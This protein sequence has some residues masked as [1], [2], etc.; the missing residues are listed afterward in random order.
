MKKICIAKWKEFE[1]GKLF[2]IKK[3]KRL[4]KADMREGDINFIGASAVNNGVTAK[5]ANNDYLHQP[6][7]ITVNYNGSVGVSFYQTEP[8][9]A[10]DDVNIL[11]PKFKL[12]KHIAMFIIPIL[13]CKGKQYAFVDKWKKE[14]MEKDIILLPSTADGQPDWAYM[15]AYIK[16]IETN[17]CN[18]IDLLYNDSVLVSNIDGQ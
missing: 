1:I 15:E 12:N 10:S 6:N 3:G 2:E 17:V 13:Q 18:Y 5:I 11:Y 16:S 7:T 8:F 4:T 9:W 14:Y